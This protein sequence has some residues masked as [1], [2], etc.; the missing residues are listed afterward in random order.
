MVMLLR[1]ELI[2][3]LGCFYVLPS[4]RIGTLFRM[5]Q[6]ASTVFIVHQMS[7]TGKI[8]ESPYLD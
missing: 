2:G 6:I 3:L 1:K 8:S 5:Q 7:R 4:Q